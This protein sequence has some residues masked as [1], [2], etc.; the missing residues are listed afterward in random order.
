MI[1]SDLVTALTSL[2]IAVQVG[3]FKGSSLPDTFV[4]IIPLFNSFESAD[5]LP[6]FDVQQA[7]TEIYTK[8]DWRSTVNSIC[9]ECIS[10]GLLVH[11]R[12]YIGRNEETG[13]FQYSITFERS[14]D[15]EDG[16]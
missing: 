2:Q 14:Y 7:A 13:Y 3:D 10:R 12:R 5:D 4:V 8:G 6:D 9:G 11:E 15:L 1:I 16:E